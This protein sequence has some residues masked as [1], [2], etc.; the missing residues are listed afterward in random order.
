MLQ[1]SL[2]IISALMTLA[3][4]FEMLRRR[5]LRERHAVWWILAGIG[6]LTISIFPSLLIWAANLLGFTIPINL[7]FFVSLFVL[8]LVALQASSEITRLERD[9]RL[10]VE[11]MAILDTRI[12]N[13]ENQ[14]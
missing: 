6:A 7:V 5:Q 8:F 13:L 3:I 2:G 9:N 10:L 4:V 11:Q 14:N 1:Y 12:K